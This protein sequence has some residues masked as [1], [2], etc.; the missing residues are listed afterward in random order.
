MRLRLAPALLVL[1]AAAAAPAQITT[2][3]SATVMVFPRVVADAQQNQDTIIQI[4]NLS[5]NQLGAHCYYVEF[6]N[7]VVT[8][9]FITLTRQQPTHWPGSIGRPGFDDTHCNPQLANCPGA[10]LDPGQGVVD[11]DTGIYTP[12]SVP[13]VAQP[14]RG[15]LICVTVDAAGSLFGANGFAG[16]ADLVNLSGT[17]LASYNAIGVQADPDTFGSTPGSIILA[18]PPDGNAN[19]CPQTWVLNHIA[20]Q[21]PDPFAGGVTVNSE[22]SIVPCTQDLTNLAPQSY[23]LQFA[24]T[25]EFEEHFSATLPTTSCGL[26]LSLSD[27]ALGNVFQFPAIGSPTARTTITTDA[28]GVFMIAE[29]NRQTMFGPGGSAARNL[30]TAGVRSTADTIR[31]DVP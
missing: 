7:C 20:E 27:M 29:E 17:D 13:G 31:V 21:A 16:R 18:P 23:V 26:V 10:G 14:F 24:V 12:G 19:A 2:S 15:E 1:C 30:H 8:D 4:T 25:N 11:P 3:Q 28:V 22:L 9:F 5:N 6:S